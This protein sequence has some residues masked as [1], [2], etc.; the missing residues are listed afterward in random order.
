MPPKV[1]AERLG[2]ANPQVTGS[3]YAHVL[4]DMDADAAVQ[5]AARVVGSAASDEAF[6]EGM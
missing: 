6:G 2:H 3:I 4:P 1:V 5:I